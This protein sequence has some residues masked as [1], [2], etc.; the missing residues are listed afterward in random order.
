[1]RVTVDWQLCE[2]NAVCTGIAP[3][4]FDLD[5][6]DNL[7]ILEEK[8]DEKLWPAVRDAAAACPQRAIILTED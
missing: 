5:D 2:S 7:T 3:T 1:M 6:D 4:V 8:P